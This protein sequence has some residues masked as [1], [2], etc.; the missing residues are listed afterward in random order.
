MTDERP[1]NAWCRKY[2]EYLEN[3]Q[4]PESFLD[5]IQERDAGDE[6]PNA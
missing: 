1:I 4:E 5:M 6:D 2:N 3:Q